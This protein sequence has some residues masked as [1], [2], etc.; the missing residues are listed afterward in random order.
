MGYSCSGSVRYT[1]YR[2]YT[3]I[4]LS[5]TSFPSLLAYWKSLHN[6]DGRG[7][8]AVVTSLDEME[9]WLRDRNVPGVAVIWP[10][11]NEE[12]PE[13]WVGLHQQVSAEFAKRRFQIIDLLPEFTK[14]SRRFSDFALT[15]IDAHPGAEANR[16]VAEQLT[17]VIA[18]SPYFAGLHR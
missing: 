16:I 7:W 13:A 9:A 6:K 17:D 4:S 5:R 15:S 11:F 1:Y 2:L 10:F 18:T 3:R 14:R 12:P 8:N